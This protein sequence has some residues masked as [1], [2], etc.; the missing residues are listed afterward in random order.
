MAQQLHKRIAQAIEN[1]LDSI[2]FSIHGGTPE[3]YE[4]IHGKNDLD[5]VIKNL[6]YVDE[7]RKK[8]IKIKNFRINGGNL[9][10]YKRN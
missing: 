3:T 9:C 7:Y 6:K 4:K 10:K 1:G 8:I 5:R 2:K